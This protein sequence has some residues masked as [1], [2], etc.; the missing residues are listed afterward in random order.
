VS[1]YDYCDWL[2]KSS[3]E[4]KNER[5]NSELKLYFIDWLYALLIGV[6]SK[7]GRQFVKRYHWPGI[8]NDFKQQTLLENSNNAFLFGCISH[9]LELDD[10]EF[11]GESHPSGILFSSILNNTQKHASLEHLLKA[12]HFGYL[13]FLS[14]GRHL[15][16]NHYEKG[17][18][19]TGTVG[20]IAATLANAYLLEFSE[21]KGQTLSALINSI[22]FSSG[23]HGI[24]GKPAKC[25]S[26]GKSSMAGI[27]ACYGPDNSGEAFEGRHGYFNMYD[28]FKSQFD[29]IILNELSLNDL[30]FI[31]IKEFPSCHCSHSIITC[32][33]KI[34]QEIVSRYNNL[35]IDV[36][37]SSYSRTIA[38]I[39]NPKTINDAFFSLE[40]CCAIAFCY[41]RVD[42]ESFK[43]GLTSCE[44][45]KIMSRIT[46][47]ED[48]S[49]EKLESIVRV[50]VDSQVFEER[51]LVDR[52]FNRYDLR[53]ITMKKQEYL[54]EKFNKNHSIDRLLSKIEKINDVTNE[55]I[56]SEVYDVIHNQLR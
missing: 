12:V 6:S 46:V 52:E 17:W 9:L 33:L 16:P 21:N 39:Q 32:V 7:E 40:F 35:K 13:G 31:K 26:S 38:S 14:M 30:S 3:R 8:R 23:V 36:F 49:L 37:V 28:S 10:S 45:K 43:D 42:S 51:C 48:S 54:I 11:I 47:Y 29:N 34:N 44:V 20:P 18:H 27:L 50:T 15:N 56:H 4:I 1:T 41:P 5:L 24:F 22:Q 25:L 19:G 53:A 55:E 2:A